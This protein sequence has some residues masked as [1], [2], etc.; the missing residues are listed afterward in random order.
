[1]SRT[2][3]IASQVIPPYSGDAITRIESE[4]GKIVLAIV[5]PD[6]KFPDPYEIA[7]RMCAALN[8][9]VDPLY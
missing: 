3:W 6:D 1:M 7:E 5:D 4:D 9:P 2:I 8:G